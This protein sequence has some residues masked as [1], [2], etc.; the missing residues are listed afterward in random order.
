MKTMIK[1]VFLAA[2]CF[3]LYVSAVQAESVIDGSS[4]EAY[5]KSVVAIHKELSGNKQ[6]LFN[7]AAVYYNAMFEW[8]VE[9][10]QSDPEVKVRIDKILQDLNGQN[11][12]AL[13]DTYII[14]VETNHNMAKKELE[15]ARKYIENATKMNAAISGFE[16]MDA[17]F[18][19]DESGV[20]PVPMIGLAVFNGTAYTVKHI[21]LRAKVYSKGRVIPWF[22]EEFNFGVQGLKKGQTADWELMTDAAAGWNT[23]PNRADLEISLEIVKL[24]TSDGR[25]LNA[26]PLPKQQDE[27]LKVLSDQIE[28]FSKELE[29][30]KKL[31]G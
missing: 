26:Y 8:S 16:I 23:I 2:I 3:L 22:E 14:V 7:K 19:F 21:Y 13:I 20:E 12:D 15:E 6:A 30:L 9:A 24:V 25:E 11:A 4:I 31:A 1:R 18:Y 29:E 27:Y 17:K 10:G 5:Q 28:V